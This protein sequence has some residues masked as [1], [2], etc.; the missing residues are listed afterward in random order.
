MSGQSEEAKSSLNLWAIGALGSV[1]GFIISQGLSYFQ[2]SRT[3]TATQRIETIHLARELTT[4]FYSG[5][6]SSTVFQPIRAA[7][8]S[9]RPIYLSNHGSFGS[10][11]INLY[12]GFFDDLGFYARRQ[13]IDDEVIDQLF[14]AYVVEAYENTEL[15]KYVADVQKNS[16]EASAFA[17]FISLA[18]RL[19]LR[20]GRAE[21]A[22]TWRAACRLA[23]KSGKSK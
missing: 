7:I 19:E 10:D 15:R 1:A 17:D 22:A 16:A 2:F 5:Q 6:N 14:G 4:D 3:L 23:S 13:M 18:E 9:C 12:L 8:E 11:S 21:L 20:P